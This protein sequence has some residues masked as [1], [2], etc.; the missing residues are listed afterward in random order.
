[1]FFVAATAH[2][3]NT[4]FNRWAGNFNVREAFQADIVEKAQWIKKQPYDI[5]KYVIT[6]AVGQVDT[7]GTPMSFQP[8]VFITDT[9]YPQK[10]AEKNIYYISIK[11]LGSADCSQK[12]LFV[13]VEYRPSIFKTIKQK[14]PDLRLDTN[15]G[16]ILLKN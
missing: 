10:Q 16:F 14:I 5:K 3:Y 2:A 7:T 8:I 1:M 11:N 9:L 12:C 15:P 6:D 13:P 4:Y